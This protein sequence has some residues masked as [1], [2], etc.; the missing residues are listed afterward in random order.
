MHS[1]LALH[2]WLELSP[3]QRLDR[4]RQE[5]DADAA[6]I[7]L[8]DECERLAQRSVSAAI[9]AARAMATLAQDS[10]RPL[11]R[12]RLLRA[13]VM[14][15]AY[16]GRSVEA[17]AA[18]DEAISAAV[19]ANRPI[20]AARARIAS[21]HPLTAVGKID[22]ALARGEEARTDL[23]AL[24][25]PQLAA[26]ADI[27]LGNI[28]KAAGN[29]DAARMHLQRARTLLA[30]EPV[31]VATIN[32]AL[33]EVHYLCDDLPASRLAFEASLEHFRAADDR[34]A[35]AML[36]GNLA[37]LAAREGLLQ[38]SL[39]HF[40]RARRTLERDDAPS[41]LARI[42]AEEAEVLD[43]LGVPAEAE[44]ALTASL[45][46]LE[47]RGHAIEAARAR[48]A[49]ASARARLGRV[50]EADADL[51]AVLAIARDSEHARLRIRAQLLGA[52]VALAVGNATK[53]RAL[54]R[55]VRSDATASRIDRMIA[56]HHL[57]RTSTALG[58]DAEMIA[59]A[60]ATI[61][62]C[63]QLGLSAL[64]SDLL[65][66]RGELHPGEP[67]S[68]DD[69]EEAVV[70][71]ERVRTTLRAER[72]RAAWTGSH[73][74]AYEALALAR[75][76]QNTPASLDAAFDAVERSKSRS[77][78]DLVQRTIDEN[79]PR[80]AVD[81]DERRLAE[82][83]DRLRRRLS[84]LYSRWDGDP[85]H[86]ERL[87]AGPAAALARSIRDEEI[88][89]DR[90]AHR[91][92]ALRGEGSVL[93]MPPNAAAV[94]HRLPRG[95]VLIEYYVAGEELLAFVMRRD[96]VCVHRRLASAHEVADLTTRVLFQMRRTTRLSAAG[97]A[98]NDDSLLPLQRAFTTLLSPLLSAIGDAHDLVI[99]P[100][101]ALHGMPFH[102]LH[103]GAAYA[104]ERWT[105]RIAPSAA[106]AVARP[107]GR[108]GAG[109]LVVG[110]ADDAAPSM[111][112]E[113]EAIAAMRKDAQLLRDEGASAEAFLARAPEKA[114]LHLA[115]HGRF[116][117]GVPHGSGVRLAD[118]WISVREI[119]DLR[120]SARLVILAG[121]ET[122][123]AAVG[124]GD[125]A[126]GLPRSFIAAGAGAVLVSQWPVHDDAAR[127]FMID[128]HRRLIY[129]E[130]ENDD[131]ALASVLRQTML[132]T[133]KE[134]PHPGF[135]AAFTLVGADRSQRESSE[136]SPTKR[137]IAVTESA[138]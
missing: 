11:P 138:T 102:A 85:R 48:L 16:A 37:D 43:V 21:L 73:T 76:A 44:A 42:A 133:M 51:D 46:W 121:C 90:V 18:A 27:N 25:Q 99:V 136:L 10:H 112:G 41:H 31:M 91:L 118:R 101:G 38:E 84:S 116:S 98:R 80:V 22:I 15:L 4:L 1:P 50:V 32:N 137:P 57:A 82:E 2:G 127:S 58:P 65:L 8:G 124:P 97:H 24:G 6:L 111:A 88:A 126:I 14:A 52:E 5:G 19:A 125:E 77:L 34:F 56:W 66:A 62:D 104:I 53:A 114:L 60:Q 86:G 122:G 135:W 79:A 49:R 110:V 40:E 26:R 95:T 120:L 94:R 9:D 113:V 55:A 20:D 68:L 3:A 71:I 45:A 81:D 130:R 96:G 92:V 17:L 132:H 39:S 89:V 63:R 107:A 70:A 78:L 108:A 83:L 61:D 131:F 100:H 134:R 93:A 123:R 7:T 72:L 75:L 29:P 115:C 87:V 106:L 74:R 109:S 69:F 35:A 28:C 128:F 59:D 33:G 67:R 129:E 12:S 103:D 119:L 54:A 64:L 117:D 105:V 13:L 36:E 30:D 23:I 47:P